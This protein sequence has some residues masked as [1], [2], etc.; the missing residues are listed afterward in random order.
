M[1][2][3]NLTRITKALQGTSTERLQRAVWAV[4]LALIAAVV[5]FVGYY[6]WDRYVH[7][8]DRSPLEL[9]TESLEKAVREDPQ[10]LDLRVS[11]AESYLRNGANDKAL[12]QANQV[13]QADPEH[14]GALWVA[15]VALVRLDRPEEAIEPLETFVDLRK[16]Q[17]MANVDTVLEAAYYYLGTSFLALDRP[18]E[19]AA[20]QEKALLIVPHDA[21]ALY[22]AGLAYQAQGKHELALERLH[23]A[24]RF[25]PNFTEVYSAMIVSYQALG[26]EAGADY[27]RGMQAFSLKDFETARTYLES[28]T[29]ALPDFAPAFLGLG[30]TYEQMGELEAAQQAIERVLALTPDD[31]AAQQ[32]LGRIQA[33]LTGQG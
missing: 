6:T 18:E 12:E 25:V 33:T 17:P 11:L 5:L 20:A 10:N 13:L 30:L 28:A 27:A 16:D 3:M 23:G 9:Q 26:D 1:P 19:A 22:Q 21:D 15:G 4:A 29:Q 32:A 24:V 7:V 31:L 14:Q 8:G 2:R